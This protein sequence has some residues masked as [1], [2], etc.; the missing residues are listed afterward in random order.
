MTILADKEGFHYYDLR[1]MVLATAHPLVA[2]DTRSTIGNPY[3]LSPDED[4][5]EIRLRN[6]PDDMPHHHWILHNFR[7]TGIGEIELSHDS[8]SFLTFDLTGTFT[9]ITYDCGKKKAPEPPAP[10]PSPP[11]VETPNPPT[12]EEPII[13]SP[14]PDEQDEMD[15]RNMPDH[16]DYPTGASDFPE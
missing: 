4:T 13:D 15:Y 11:P 12:I 14:E 6:K 2:G 7:P 5:L 8:A 3:G 16:E 10:P 1:N 9:H